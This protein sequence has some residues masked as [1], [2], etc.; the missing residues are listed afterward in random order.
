[1]KKLF[2]LIVFILPAISQAQ[3]D[4]APGGSV[5]L[6]EKFQAVF[7]AN[8]VT[9]KA[10]GDDAMYVD[11]E[12]TDWV[13]NT[14]NGLIT[15]SFILSLDPATPPDQTLSLSMR[16]S[17]FGDAGFGFTTSSLTVNVIVSL[18]NIIPFQLSS[19]E[20]FP[21]PFQETTT[22]RFT[23]D[24]TSRVHLEVFD[25]KGRLIRV[26]PENRLPPGE[27]LLNWDGR[28][29]SGNSLPLGVYYGMVKM[30]GQ[31]TSIARMVKQ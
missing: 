11:I 2:L 30:D 24:R 4:V 31:V 23:S 20:S 29:Q 27:H 8:S 13:Q 9:V 10:T 22:I 16:Y 19:L 6:V 28:G 14:S 5:E 3:V 7:L 12:V 15:V 26:L 17:Y 21:N 18:F 1:M 25:Q